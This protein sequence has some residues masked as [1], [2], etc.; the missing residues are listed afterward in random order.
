MSSPDSN[1]VLIALREA[2]DFAQKAGLKG[3]ASAFEEFYKRFQTEKPTL[4]ELRRSVEPVRNEFAIR[5]SEA[6]YDDRRSPRSGMESLVKQYE[7]LSVALLDVMYPRE[8][9]SPEMDITG[10]AGSEHVKDKMV[11]FEGDA[12]GVGSIVKSS[13]V[14]VRRY[15]EVLGSGDFATAYA[16]TD[17]GLRGWMSL[18]RFV[19][20]HERAARKFNGPALEFQIGRFNYIYADEAARKKSNT[21][22]EGWVKGTAKENRRGAVSGFWIRDRAAQTGCGGTLWIAEEMG[23]YRIAKFDYWTP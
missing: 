20:E 6:L 16:L 10:I 22:A 14:L 15:F 3:D 17:S 9:K 4:K 8:P 2:A 13:V 5:I 7:R 19:G 18:Q 12:S 1:A 11:T 21:S 23:D